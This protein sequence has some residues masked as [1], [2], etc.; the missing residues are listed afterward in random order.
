MRVVLG[1]VALRRERTLE[2]WDG[3]VEST[4]LEEV[5]TDVVVRVAELRIDRDRA[6]ALGDRFFVTLLEAER[7][8]EEGV[9]LRGRVPCQYRR[10]GVVP[11]VTATTTRFGT[12]RAVLATATLHLVAALPGD[13]RIPLE[14]AAR[15]ARVVLANLVDE[16]LSQVSYNG[17]RDWIDRHR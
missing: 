8:A 4:E 2:P 6:L 9:R 1:L 10:S 7:P 13:E 3:V 12:H 16:R 5:G 15:L 11:S 14:L 17:T